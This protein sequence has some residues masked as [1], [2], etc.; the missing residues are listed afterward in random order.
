[1]IQ[2]RKI[3]KE[4]KGTT[5]VEMLAALTLITIMLAMAAGALSSASRIFIR[6]Q[7]QQYAQ[8]ILDTT[9]TELRALT[10]DAANYVKV[11]KDGTE[12]ADQTGNLT[13]NAIEFMN[14][15]GYLVL[16]SAEGCDVTDIYIKNN[17]V[18][19][20]E[21]VLPGRLFTRYYFR[22]SDGS[23]VYEDGTTPVARAMTMAFG[24]GFYM[25]NY[26]GIEFVIPEG[27][28]DGDQ[29]S[30]ITANVTLYSDEERT[31]P[32]AAD[33]EVLEFR[34]E[35]RYRDTVTAIAQ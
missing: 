23:Y 24:E 20:E 29:L 22:N 18:G 26:L 6:L 16:I 35:V 1:M 19:N 15:Q 3:L 28:S 9:M 31:Q 5:L 34:Y 12:I 8:S 27:T 11:Y 7:K 17:K 30:A 14:D 13:G 32:I 4:K 25:K 10:K 33:T 21:A 2:I